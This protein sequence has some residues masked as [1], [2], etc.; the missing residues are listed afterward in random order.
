MSIVCHVF[1]DADTIGA[2]LALALVLEQSGK[3][4]QVSFA[5][6]EELPDSLHSLP[7]GHLLVAPETL[8][9]DA[10]LVVTGEG[11]L[12]EQ[13]LHGKAP[14]AVAALAA[15]RGIAVVAVCGV[16]KLD[17]TGH[18]ELG[19]RQSYSLTDFA[20]DLDDAMTNG[21]ALL[22]TIG[23]RLATDQLAG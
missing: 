7:G 19:V 22:E 9:R 8:R 3:E 2:G 20:S 12:D 4:V 15:E 18:A 1:P 14:A 5:E 11:A 23:A 21:A 6:P 13:T 16:D 10:D 17:D